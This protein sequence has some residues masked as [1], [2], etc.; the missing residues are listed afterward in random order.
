[1]LDAARRRRAPRP[2]PPP[3]ASPARA[4]RR[5]APRARSDRARR[6]A[7]P[8]PAPPSPRSLSA[9]AR[10]T[11]TRRSASVSARSTTTLARESSAALTSNDGFSVVAPIEHDRARLDV[12]QER[13]LL[14]L[15]EAVDLVDEQHRALVALIALLRRLGH[16]L[17]QILDARHDRRERDEA[18]VR[19]G[20]QQARQRGLAG[21]R[22][23]PQDQRRQRPR[24]ERAP[25]AACPGPGCAPARRTPPACAAA[26][27]RPAAAR[28][29]P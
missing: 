16:R 20:R 14:R 7:R 5:R 22:R 12:G 9:S 8:A 18:R 11:T 23:P 29:D 17:A 10:S 13:V 3:P 28:A 26:S 15:V 2:R 24:L 1:M 25:Q 19:L 6:R 21:A 4:A 27:A